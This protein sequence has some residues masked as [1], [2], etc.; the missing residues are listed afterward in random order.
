[1]C[2]VDETVPAFELADQPTAAADHQSNNGTLC[3]YILLTYLLLLF[4]S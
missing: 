2:F 4:P 1:M 3:C